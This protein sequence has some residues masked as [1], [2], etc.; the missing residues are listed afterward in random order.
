MHNIFFCTVAG[1]CPQGWRK[2]LGSCHMF[3]ANSIYWLEWEA[4]RQ[5]CRMLQGDLA[6]M[7]SSDIQNAVALTLKNLFVNGRSLFVGFLQEKKWTWSDGSTFH[8]SGVWRAGFPSLL[9]TESCAAITG[10]GLVDIQCGG[11]SQF[12][13]GQGEQWVPCFSYLAM[14]R[15][16]CCLIW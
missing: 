3:R 6:V 12:I 13:C 15:Y 14:L 16:S 5:Q 8:D 11:R 1:T 9:E 4:A 7:N 10:S 2:I